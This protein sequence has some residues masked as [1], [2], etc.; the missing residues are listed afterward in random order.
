MKLAVI[1]PVYN[2][3]DYLKLCIESI[4][5]N[6]NFDYT[7]VWAI[8]DCS[9][10]DTALFLKDV[11]IK[12]GGKIKILRNEENLGFVKTCNRGLQ[13][14]DADVY[15][16]LNSD[17]IIPKNFCEKIVKC[18]EANKNTGLASPIGSFSSRYYIIKPINLSLDEI[19]EKLERIHKTEYPKIPSAEGF[20]FC[21]RKETKDKIG[22]LDTIYGKGYSEE[23]DYSYRA[24]QQGLQ[25]TLIDNL[26]VY[27]KNNCSFGAEKRKE[28]MAVNSKIF[29]DRWG[30]FYK[31]WIKNNKHINPIKRIRKEFFKDAIITNCEKAYMVN[32][33]GK[34]FK[35]KK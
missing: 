9:N 22:L 24:I 14:A 12:S 20:C 6:V 5:S 15:I 16:L 34:L 31:E 27:H 19:N 21:I 17:T 1:I 11:E 35:I 7:S 10:D 33:F 4:L 3:L 28:Y 29:Q 32:I 25:C 30:N 13:N 2:A 23:I 18:F 8:D 26:Y